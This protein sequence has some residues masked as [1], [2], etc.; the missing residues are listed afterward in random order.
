MTNQTRKNNQANDP[1]VAELGAWVVDQGL[2]GRPHI[3]L[4]DA[5]CQ[6]LVALG[7]PLM[8]AH[9]TMNALHPVYGAVGFDWM[10]RDGPARHEYGHTTQTPDAWQQSPFFHMLSTGATTYRE[11][12]CDTDDASRFPLL[13]EMKGLGATDYFAAA[14]A[15]GAQQDVHPD[16]VENGQEGALMSW[17]SHAPGGF[18]DPDIDLIT[19]VLPTLCL[20]LKAGSNRQMAEDLLGVYLG[21]DAGQRVLSG[22]IQ[23]GS[24]RWIDAVICYFD[25]QGFTSMSQQIAGESLLAMLNDYFG[26]VV[27]QIEQNGGNV[28][29]FMGDGLLAIFDR[30]ALSDAPQRALKMTEAL[31]HDMA[32]RSH[33]RAADGLPTLGYTMAIHAGPVLYGN[34]GGDAR[35]DFTVIGPEVNLAARM[36]GMHHALGQRTIVSQTV[37]RDVDRDASGLVS[38]GRYMMRG[39]DQPQELF[40]IYRGTTPDAP[41]PS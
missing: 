24:S 34:M 5:Y 6:K 1:R 32:A 9:V 21:R 15:F 26:V 30:Q 31:E 35:L 36:A 22:E 33:A 7:V 29:K 20:T 12:L 11:R 38:L 27:E 23:R 16:A 14:T 8:R 2:R 28:L 39:V 40:T 10:D 41:Q 13:N 37:A 18:S 4:L 3:D 25:L 19:A 17:M